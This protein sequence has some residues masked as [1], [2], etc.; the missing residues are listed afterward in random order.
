MLTALGL[1]SDGRVVAGAYEASTSPVTGVVLRFTSTGALD[2][3]FGAAG[4]TV[5]SGVLVRSLAVDGTDRIVAAGSGGGQ[6]VAFRLTSAG[7]LDT[8]FGTGGESRASFGATSAEVYRV[9][10]QDDGKIVTL[11]QN[12]DSVPAENAMTMA[13]FTANGALDPTFGTSGRAL[14]SGPPGPSPSPVD[15]LVTRCHILTV[16]IDRMAVSR[17]FR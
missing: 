14:T 13:R 16:H 12:G 15:A 10:L 3:S 1:T 4:K 2:A 11:G 6:H 17:H 9:A 5:S 8:S 7:A